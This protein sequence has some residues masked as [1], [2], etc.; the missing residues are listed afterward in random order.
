[1]RIPRQE[2]H[3]EGRSV[4]VCR[5]ATETGMV[6]AGGFGKIFSEIKEWATREGFKQ[7]LTYADL[8]TGTGDVY[9]KSGFSLVGETGPAYW[10][11]DGVSRFDRFKYRASGGKSERD[12]A[13]AAGVYRV[14]GAG[15]RIFTMPL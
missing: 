13:G 3:R 15:S 12:V 4:E 1:M 11:T 2:K 9:A 7:V 10:Y 5:F 14:Y 6:V 8:D